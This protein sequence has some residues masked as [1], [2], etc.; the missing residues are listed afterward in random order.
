MIGD[1]IYVPFEFDDGGR[2]Y[3]YDTTTSTFT[4]ILDTVTVAP[5]SV[6]GYDDTLFI[7]GRES[8]NEAVSIK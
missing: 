8:S 5:F 3:V 4:D 7:I 6:R 2:I 1:L